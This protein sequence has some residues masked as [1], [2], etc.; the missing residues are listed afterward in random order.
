MV[1]ATCFKA[2][3]IVALSVA[4]GVLFHGLQYGAIGPVRWFAAGG[5]LVALFTILPRIT[6]ERLSLERAIDTPPDL[7]RRATEWIA[8]FAGFAVILV[9]TKSGAVYSRGWLV[10]FF[11]AGLVAIPMLEIAVRRLARRC[12]GNGLLEPRQVFLVGVRADLRRLAGTIRSSVVARA[13]GARELDPDATVA[14]RA[15]ALADAVA[16][17]RALATSDVVLVMPGDRQDLI[18]EAVE[19]FAVLPVAVHLDISGLK[20]RYGDLALQQIGGMSALAL[21][22]APL[23]PA[24]NFVKRAFDLGVSGF[25][26]LLILPVLLLIAVAIRLD[27]PGPVFYRQRRR[28]YNQREFTILKFRSMSVASESGGFRQATQHDPRITRVG[29]WLR[30]TNLDE[31]PQLINVLR[32]EMSIVGPRPHAVDHDLQFEDRIRRYPRRLNVRPGITGWAQINGL[33]GETDTDD[34]MARRVEHDLYYI[35]NWS[36]WLDMFIVFA[37]VVSPK[38]YRNAR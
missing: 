27:S 29:L 12:I 34:K 11:L 8:A 1:A 24:E 26:L 13:V 6:G 3:M 2:F 30:R 4:A 31:L 33:R 7:A 35:D 5:A 9:L 21:D 22:K 14:V 15:A 28:G 32:G 20:Q 38:S 18:A 36:L 16:T 23:S 10:L 17:A 37:T 19:A 25:G